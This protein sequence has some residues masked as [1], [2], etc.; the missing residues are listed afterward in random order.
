MK[1]SMRLRSI[2]TLLSSLILLTIGCATT[3]KEIVVCVSDPLK[4]G[5]ECYMGGL[6]KFVPYSDTE[7]YICIPYEDSRDLFER[8]Q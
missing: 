8:L 5:V 2:R 7:D 4:G 1:P 6:V 3:R